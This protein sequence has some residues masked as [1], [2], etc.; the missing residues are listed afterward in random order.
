MS[1]AVDHERFFRERIAALKA[2]GRYRW[3][4]ELERQAGRF[5]QALRY[6]AGPGGANAPS[7]ITVWCSND[8]LGMGQ[9]PSVL[10]AMHRAIDRSGAGTGGTRNISGTNR[11][12]IERITWAK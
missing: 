3:F 1:P 5:P 11:R 4:A 8:Y 2:E 6:P 9:H 12:G 7:E 10:A